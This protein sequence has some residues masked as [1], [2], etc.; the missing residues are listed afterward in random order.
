[1]ISKVQAL[2]LAAVAVVLGYAIARYAVPTFGGMGTGG[3][4][5]GVTKR[6][7][8]QLA[9]PTTILA[10]PQQA[11]SSPATTEL[12]A[13]L[14]WPGQ[15]AP[16]GYGDTQPLSNPG[17][18]EDP[19][20]LVATVYPSPWL[21]NWRKARKFNA[22]PELVAVVD[23]KDPTKLKENP[24]HLIGSTNCVYLYH[25]RGSAEGM[26]WSAA[27]T[28]LQN[29]Q[30]PA[31]GCAPPPSPNPQ[32]PI[33]VGS[34]QDNALQVAPAARF[35]DAVLEGNTIKYNH[36]TVLASSADSHGARLATP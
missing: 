5:T 20:N 7:A 35:V 21:A 28:Q 17:G 6:A 8:F 32:L 11:P 1:M 36:E 30:T 15:N 29:P 26:G 24:L 3:G 33:P 9:T 25:T 2:L 16:N 14:G 12:L 27:V 19:D 13:A 4:G 31:D 10:M 18:T 23:V 22:R 34:Y